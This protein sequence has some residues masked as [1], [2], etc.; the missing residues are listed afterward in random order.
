M[1][2]NVRFS[3]YGHYEFDIVREGDNWKVF[4]LDAGK[5]LL[6]NDVVIPTEVQEDEV[7]TYLDDLFHELAKPGQAIRRLS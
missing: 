4:N 2:R 1:E 7:A 5:R 6:L 3:I